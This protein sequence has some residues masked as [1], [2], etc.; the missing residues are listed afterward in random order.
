MSFAQLFSDN[1]LLIHLIIPF[2]PYYVIVCLHQ[3]VGK[4]LHLPSLF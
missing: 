2:F 1:H 3:L 4:I